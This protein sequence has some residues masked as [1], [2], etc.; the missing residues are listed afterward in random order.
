MEKLLHCMLDIAEEMTACGAEVNRIE[1]TLKRLGL[2]YGASRMNVF[3][4]TSSIVITMEFWDGR[5]FTQS[6]RIE[7]SGGT[8]FKKL[9][10]INELSRKCCACPMSVEHLQDELQD[11]KKSVSGRRYFYM[12]SM[13]AAGSF[14][15]FF[16]GDLGDG[17]AAACFAVFIC[18]LQEKL[19]PICLNK[20][21]F[22]L[23]CSF[24]VGISICLTARWIPV[25]RADMIMI[26]DIMLL[27]PGISMTNAVRD[28]LM[29][30]TISGIMR[31]IET[32]LW[33]GSLA[34]GFMLAIWLV[35][36]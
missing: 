19:I 14:A 25:L 3:V 7:N 4:I 29:G 22:Y 8:D 10:K 36:G 6:R 17:L 21:T 5:H 15:V 32:F 35:G 20:M 16:G 34:S 18:I 23:L 11:I 27:I 28:V 9:E 1:D 24:L 13:L 12:G 33:A 2:A 30:D 31:F 26:G